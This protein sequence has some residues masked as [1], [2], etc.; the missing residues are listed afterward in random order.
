MKNLLIVDDNNKYAVKLA[1]YFQKLGYNIDYVISG[2]KGMEI[3]EQKGQ[4]YYSALVTDITMEKRLAGIY[5]VYHLWRNN[6]RGTVMVASTGIDLL[7][8]RILFR[9]FLSWLPINYM[10]PKKSILKD[11]P[12]FYCR[13]P[14]TAPLH[15][16]QEIKSEL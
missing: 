10:I 9:I 7:F 15:H 12:L 2:R 8:V 11:K 6:Y 14:F 4:E 13:S 3:L 5:L 16:F 1:N